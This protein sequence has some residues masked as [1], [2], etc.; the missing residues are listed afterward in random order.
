MRG[1]RL[2]AL[3]GWG[4]AATGHLLGFCEGLLLSGGCSDCEGLGAA[5]TVRAWELQQL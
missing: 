4:A 3:G 1:Q 5:A 2:K